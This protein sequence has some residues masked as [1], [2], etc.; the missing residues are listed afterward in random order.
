[1]DI[2]YRRL[3][4]QMVVSLPEGSEC[5]CLLELC[6]KLVKGKVMRFSEAQQIIDSVKEVPNDGTN[7]P[8]DSAG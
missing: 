4:S 6:V 2:V 1:M 5:E 8:V 3:K 7:D